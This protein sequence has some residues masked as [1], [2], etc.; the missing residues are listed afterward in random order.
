MS[1]AWE[2]WVYLST[3]AIELKKA[4]PF[5]WNG[6]T[7]S[8]KVRRKRKVCSLRNGNMPQLNLL[9]QKRKS[10]TV[11]FLFVHPDVWTNSSRNVARLK[12][13]NF[14]DVSSW[15]W[16]FAWAIQFKKNLKTRPK[17]LAKNG[18]IGKKEWCLWS[19][20][21][22]FEKHDQ[23]IWQRFVDCCHIYSCLEDNNHNPMSIITNISKYRIFVESSYYIYT[24]TLLLPNRNLL[25][26]QS[27]T[28][29]F[30]HRKYLHWSDWE[31]SFLITIHA[32]WELNSGWKQWMILKIAQNETHCSAADRSKWWI[33]HRMLY[34]WHGTYLPM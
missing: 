10:T 30:I 7:M 34:W 1:S 2:L 29:R 8:L 6:R 14:F 32:A 15:L 21:V 31:G 27:E 18:E 3:W 22:L 25:F 12:E 20:Q 19:Q 13:Y 28:C 11:P 24:K 16:M 5:K 23:W 4:A 26:E 9:K 17:D 33:S